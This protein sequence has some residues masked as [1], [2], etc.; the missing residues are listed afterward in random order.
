MVEDAEA[1]EEAGCFMIV[2]EAMPEFVATEIT[3]MLSI[4]TIGIGAGNQCSGQV[5]VQNDM[6]G[7][8]DKFVP[9]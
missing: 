6:L 4:P 7:V 8:F 9:K 1:L 5:L 3:K 2:L